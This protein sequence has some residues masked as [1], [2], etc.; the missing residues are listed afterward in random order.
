MYW[1][2]EMAEKERGISPK[3][4]LGLL[5][6]LSVI[7]CKRHLTMFCAQDSQTVAAVLALWCLGCGW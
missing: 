1:M 3:P 6:K 2:W 4:S 5:G 7:K